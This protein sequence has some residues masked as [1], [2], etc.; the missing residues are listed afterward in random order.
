[1]SIGS[2]WCCHLCALSLLPPMMLAGI[3]IIRCKVV[4]SK[5]SIQLQVL[6]IIVPAP[7]GMPCNSYWTLCS[8]AWSAAACWRPRVQPLDRQLFGRRMQQP[9]LRGTHH[10]PSVHVKHVLSRT[11]CVAHLR[12]RPPATPYQRPIRAWQARKQG[13]SGCLAALRQHRMFLLTTRVLQV[14]RHR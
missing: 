14:V 9:L 6:V 2:L 3:K 7:G 12:S 8:P 13:C 5:M 1:M 11:L 4:Q 10:I